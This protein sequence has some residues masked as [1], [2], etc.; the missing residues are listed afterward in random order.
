MSEKKPRRSYVLPGAGVVKGSLPQP[1]AVPSSGFI[2]VDAAGC[3]GCR[4]CEMVC[5]MHHEG[6]VRPSQARLA[7]SHDLFLQAH[8]DVAVCPQCLGPECLLV[9][10]TGAISADAVTGARVVDEDVCNGCGLCVKACHLRMIKLE[11]SRKKAL[12]C[13]LCGGDPQCAAHCPQGVIAFK[14]RRAS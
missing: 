8:P 6:E 5:A 12:K 7:V 13:D 2:T 9:C 10:P 3:S 1:M 4:V 14:E 11:P